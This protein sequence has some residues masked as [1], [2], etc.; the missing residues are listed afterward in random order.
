MRL[1]TA[2][3][4]TVVMAVGLVAATGGPAQAL[5][6]TCDSFTSSYASEKPQGRAPY[7]HVPSIGTDSGNYYCSLVQGNTGWGVVVLQEALWSC[8]EQPID[9]DGIFGTLTK[10]ALKN[11]QR[12]INQRSD[13]DIVVDGEYGNQTRRRMLKATFDHANVGRIIFGQCGF[14]GAN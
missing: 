5:L 2:I 13:P 3:V 9:N 11:A 12:I 6:P 1:A 7:Y 8:Y 10:E 14:A 4:A